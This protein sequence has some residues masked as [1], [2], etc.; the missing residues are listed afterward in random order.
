MRDNQLLK[1]NE[2]KS[3]DKK[4]GIL[5]SM[6]QLDCDREPIED[7]VGLRGLLNKSK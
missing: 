2:N 3:K 6:E 4:R 7:A 5:S 1:T